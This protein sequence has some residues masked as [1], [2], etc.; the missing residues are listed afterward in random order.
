MDKEHANFEKCLEEAQSQLGAKVVPFQLPI[1]QGESF[2]GV[3]DILKKKAYVYSGEGKFTETDVPADLKGTVDEGSRSSSISRPRRTIRCSRS[4]SE[5]TSFRTR[6]CGRG[7]PTGASP[8]R[9]FRSSS[10]RRRRTSASTSS[11]NRSSTML[12]S[13]SVAGG[14]RRRRLPV[15][16]PSAKMKTGP[17]APRGVRIQ[18]RVREERRRSLLLQGVRRRGRASA[19]ISTTRTSTPRSA[20]GSSSSSRA[21]TGS[22]PNRSRRAISAPR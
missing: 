22:I 5:A 17:G 16:A 8:A 2:K 12:P 19:R 14:D 11:W 21:G 18:V 3:V 9:S 7:S 20:S 13:P 10:P 6:S 1:G 15:R 4:S